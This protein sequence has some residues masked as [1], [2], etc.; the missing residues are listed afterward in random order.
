MF[1]KFGE[2]DSVEELNEE[3]RKLKEAGDED[4][5]KELCEENGIDIEDAEDYMDG[6]FEELTNTSLAAVGKLKVEIKDLKLEKILKDWADELQGE[7]VSSEEMARAVR[8]KGKNLAGYL[9]MLAD[10]GFKDKTVVCR[11]IVDKCSGDLKKI[12]G[13]HEFYIGV[14]DKAE[15]RKIMSG[16]YLGK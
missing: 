8:R 9:A 6:C 16:Y 3:A 14:P 12:V 13:S 15:R 4:R 2:F 1:E 7:C 5:L 10:A 11:K